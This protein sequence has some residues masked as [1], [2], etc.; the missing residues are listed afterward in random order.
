MTIL[1]RS[2][3]FAIMGGIFSVAATFLTVGFKHQTFDELL[4][5]GCLFV[6]ASIASGCLYRANPE[7]AW[8][9]F[10]VW[11]KIIPAPKR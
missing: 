1:V 4:W 3:A 11:R 2:L 9:L 7:K 5:V 10:S 8:D 6:V